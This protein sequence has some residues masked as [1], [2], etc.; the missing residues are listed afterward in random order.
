MKRWRLGHGPK[1]PE[2][3]ERLVEATDIIR[4][5]RTGRPVQHQGPYCQV[6]ARLYDPPRHAVP[7]FMAANGPKAMHRAG[8][9][10]DGLI[11]DPKIWKQHR[12][13]FAGGEPEPLAKI[14]DK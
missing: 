1:W 2:R 5:L 4:Q 11:T 10:G 14:L 9:D 7:L 13:E 6:N 8:Q 3:S 12:S